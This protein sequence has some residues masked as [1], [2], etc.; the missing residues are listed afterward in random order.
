MNLTLGF[1]SFIE[2]GIIFM[3]AMAI[4]NEQHL[5]KKCKTRLIRD[6]WHIPTMQNSGGEQGM[7]TA[8]NQVIFLI[9]TMRKYGKCN[10]G[11]TRTC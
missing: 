4:L 2:S 11:L 8:K 7:T 1:W 9:F 10:L 6:G 5:L 3:N